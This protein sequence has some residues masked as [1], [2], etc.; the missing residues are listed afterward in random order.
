M[1]G[2]A[3]DGPLLGPAGS[4]RARGPRHLPIRGSGTVGE[5]MNGIDVLKG[6]CYTHV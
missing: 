6:M 2:R 5:E 1:Q 4:S 3:L